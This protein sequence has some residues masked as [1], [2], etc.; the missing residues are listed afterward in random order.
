MIAIKSETWFRFRTL[1]RSRFFA[2]FYLPLFALFKCRSPKFY[3]FN[4]KI[5]YFNFY[6][7]EARVKA[8]WNWTLTDQNVCETLRNED[9]LN[10]LEFE[11]DD[12]KS[13][14]CR[15]DDSVEKEEIPSHFWQNISWNQFTL[16]FINK[17]VVWTKFSW[18]DSK[19]KFP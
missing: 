18:K 2:E 13:R 8:K 3:V 5:A 9:D 1:L 17:K 6:L 10:Y 15:W 16:W 4:A 14:P 19:S 7:K 12:Y 11:T